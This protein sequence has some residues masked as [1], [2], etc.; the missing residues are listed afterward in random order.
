M[1]WYSGR[2]ANSTFVFLHSLAMK[3]VSVVTL[4][5]VP[6]AISAT[7]VSYDPTYDQ[8]TE[9]LST[10]SCSDGSNGLLTKGYS[11]FEDLPTFPNIGGSSVVV[12][13]NSPNCG[14]SC[15]TELDSEAGV[16]VSLCNRHLLEC[17]FPGTD[18]HSD[19]DRS[20]RRWFQPF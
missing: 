12:S 9:S 4:L 11:L 14:S 8:G 5:A 3:F 1:W 16:G 18:D 10:V 19:S 20:C 13:Y 2:Q 15:S 6:F 7:R 17:N